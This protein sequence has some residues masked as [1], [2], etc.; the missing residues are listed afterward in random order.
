VTGQ[1]STTYWGKYS[2]KYS[3]VFARVRAFLESPRL[4]IFAAILAALLTSPSLFSG[5]A[6]EDWIQRDLIHRGEY[7][8]PERINL[9]GRDREWSLAEIEKRDSEYQLYGWFPWLADP[10]FD[11]SFWRPVASLT[12]HLDYRAWPEQAWLMHAESIGWYA[13]LV[14][15]IGVLHRRLV[16]KRWIAGLATLLYAA[17]DAH[18][19]PV[20]WLMNRNGVMATFFAILALVNYDRFRRDGWRP[21]AFLTALFFGLGLCTAEFALCTA[22]YFFAYLLFVDEAKWKKRLVAASCWAAVLVAWAVAYRWLGHATR[23]SGLYVDPWADP[24]SYAFEVVERATMLLLGL[25]GAPFAD[26]WLRAAPYAQGLLVFWAVVFLSTVV[27]VLWPLLRSDRRARFWAAGLV[28]SLPPACATF[29]DDRLLLCAGVGAFPLVGLLVDALFTGSALL[30]TRRRAAEALGAFFVGA[31][32][33][34]APVLLPYRSLQMYHYDREIK[35]AGDSAFAHVANT[36]VGALIVV[37]GQ[38][39][40]F[41]GMTALT[42]LSRGQQTILRM[43][44]LAGTLDDVE[45]RRLDPFRLEVTPKDGFYS[46][47]FNRIFRGRADKFARGA[48]VD[49]KGVDVTVTEVNQWGE[50]LSAIFTFA[51]P[52]EHPAYTWISWKNGRYEVFSPPP[53]GATVVVRGS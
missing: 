10:H 20:G 34:A 25:F 3:S 26:S 24:V 45:L 31:H 7:P 35:E 46:R 50:P 11:A 9:F 28:M 2:A 15:A 29:P 8:L 51:L 6:T 4:P 27:F 38:N 13:A 44:T 21:G 47:V 22:G 37:N 14:Y 33:L 36:P 53:V 41:V 30:R 19:H 5:L 43:L 40:Y 18:G 12:H 32:A 1:P 49:L 48:H 39:Y 16:S 23:G 52:L 17:D 42:R